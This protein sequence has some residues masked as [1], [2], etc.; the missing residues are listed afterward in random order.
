MSLHPNGFVRKKIKFR[1]GYDERS[2][3]PPYLITTS[4]GCLVTTV[5][6]QSSTYSDV[7]SLFFPFYL[8]AIISCWSI[9]S[10]ELI[11]RSSHLLNVLLSHKNFI[12]GT[13]FSVPLSASFIMFTMKR[14]GWLC[15]C[16]YTEKAYS[17]LNVSGALSF[18]ILTL[19][20]SKKCRLGQRRGITVTAYYFLLWNKV[21]HGGGALR[22]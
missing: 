12:Q 13:S 14:D 1:S 21:F 18:S 6:R 2:Y 3:N 10:Q 9:W 19:R 11:T 16:S 20:D 15:I 7:A 5:R 22:C 17:V 4:V 8:Y